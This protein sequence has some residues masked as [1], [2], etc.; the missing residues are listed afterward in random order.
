MRRVSALENEG[1]GLIRA[2][3][4]VSIA[5]AIGYACSFFKATLVASYLGVGWQMDAFL[6]A[7]ALVDWITMTISGPLDGA[8][9]PVYVSLRTE[10]ERAAMR[11]VGA[12]MGML[13]SSLGGMLLI[14]VVLAPQIPAWILG[15]GPAEQ[16]RLATV[17]LWLLAPRIIL[18]GPCSIYSAVLNANRA[19]FIPAIASTAQTVLVI[20]GLLLS[21]EQWAVYANA[22]GVSV[23]AL[24]QWLILG[25]TVRRHGWNISWSLALR[26]PGVLRFLKLL[27]PLVVTRFLILSLPVIDRT[28]AAHF[29]E[30]TI[31][32][33]GYSQ[34]LMQ[35][36]VMVFLSALQSTMLPFLSQER[37]QHGIPGLGRLFSS[38]IRGTI[39]FFAPLTILM[40]V[41]REPIVR[42]VLERGRFDSAATALTAVPF[43]MY[44]L[45]V[46]PTAVTYVSAY[47][48]LAL[49]DA[50]TNALLGSVFLFCVKV[51]LNQPL[52]AVFGYSGLALATS[53]AYL[54]TG[55][56]MLYV[57]WRRG[58]FLVNRTFLVGVFK[59]GVLLSL[60]VM[61]LAEAGMGV[62]VNNA[63]LRLVLVSGLC[64]VGYYLVG[65]MLKVDELRVIQQ[66]IGRF[67]GQPA[68][69]EQ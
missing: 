61:L 48:F 64:V 28:I 52:V 42:F 59:G 65:S 31:S 34:T 47:T 10:G 43:G 60:A 58:V 36:S 51:V 68:E 44:L 56:A 41:M 7:Y 13:V 22:I 5:L 25:T 35:M 67:L 57:L 30:G 2:T 69:A 66:R 1:P 49:E 3:G 39:V 29:P 24:T 8:L 63:L 46:V 55:I 17:L 19:F 38:M 20:V 37:V 16:G 12:V 23:G 33:L 9:I 18:M 32:A 14:V 54:S 26:A 50:R 21:H 40:L 15:V 6:W 62:S 11:F 4:V 45:G 27:W 53:V